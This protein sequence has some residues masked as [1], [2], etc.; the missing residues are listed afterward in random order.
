[1][2]E[3]C[4]IRLGEAVRTRVD[5]GS[6]E[7]WRSSDASRPAPRQPGGAACARPGVGKRGRGRRPRA[8]AAS[9]DEPPFTARERL[10]LHG[11]RV[12]FCYYHAGGSAAV[13]RPCE[14]GETRVVP[15]ARLS[16]T[17]PGL[18]RQ[19]LTLHVG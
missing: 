4:E 17:R 11:R 7:A 9:V 10:W 5:R 3:A 6:L 1:M 16:R 19:P 18:A 2:R 13:V 15:L 14:G 12:A 8:Y